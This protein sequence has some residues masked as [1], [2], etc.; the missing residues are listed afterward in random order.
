MQQL[1][2]SLQ[3]EE[4]WLA[5]PQ[6]ARH[7]S[8]HPPPVGSGALHLSAKAVHKLGGRALWRD[9]HAACLLADSP[10]ASAPD[11]RLLDPLGRPSHH[12]QAG[13]HHD[14]RREARQEA[15]GVQVGVL[16]QVRRLAVGHPPGQAVEPHAEAHRRRH[17]KPLG[18]ERQKHKVEGALG[19]VVLLHRLDV[20]R[21]DVRRQEAEPANMPPWEDPLVAQL[22]LSDGVPQTD[23]VRNDPARLQLAEIHLGAVEL[24]LHRLLKRPREGA[25]VVEEELVEQHVRLRQGE[26]PAGVVAEVAVPEEWLVRPAALAC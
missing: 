8:D 11:I 3:S 9:D 18:V 1:L 24:G 4:A 6:R 10:Q 5:H 15:R 12:K 23:K 20:L 17:D 16:V 21:H 2:V 22:L 13:P 19:A 26:G 7:V 25:L 14:E